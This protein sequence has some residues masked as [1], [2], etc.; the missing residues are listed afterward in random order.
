M[1]SHK[2][3]LLMKSLSVWQSWNH[4]QTASSVGV[5]D[6]QRNVE[7]NNYF[8]TDL[9]GLSEDINQNY[10]QKLGDL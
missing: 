8:D 10:V 9:F 5:W 4:D 6:C 3:H 2:L 7:I 1:P